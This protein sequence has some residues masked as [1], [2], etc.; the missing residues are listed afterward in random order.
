[1]KLALKT[2]NF[3]LYR[4][5]NGMSRISL[6]QNM[7]SSLKMPEILLLKMR[8]KNLHPR[9]QCSLFPDQKLNKRPCL[10]WINSK[11]SSRRQET[12]EAADNI[13][14]I[15]EHLTLGTTEVST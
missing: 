15:T 3:S 13:R 6:T 10:I 7:R 1:M 14:M 5:M 2:C 12:S 4:L 9:N 8:R 11:L